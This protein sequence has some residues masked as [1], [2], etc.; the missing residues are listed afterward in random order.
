MATTV[1]GKDPTG[2]I[3]A[4]MS[5]M[6]TAGRHA[7]NHWGHSDGFNSRGGA[8]RRPFGS[9]SCLASGS[10]CSHPLKPNPDA[11]RPRRPRGCSGRTMDRN[12]VLCL[13]RTAILESEQHLNPQ[14]PLF[15]CQG[16]SMDGAPHGFRTAGRV[17]WSAMGYIE[18]R[19]PTR[20]AAAAA[21]RCCGSSPA[22]D[23]I[24]A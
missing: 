4:S 5:P 21:T 14:H 3:R 9:S 17:R 7:P 18:R 12:T 6:G 11:L 16:A 15:G 24:A 22:A 13:R 10:T 19:C 1:D 20:L 2:L 8:T 23:T